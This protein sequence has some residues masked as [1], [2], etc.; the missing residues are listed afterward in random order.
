MIDGVSKKV[1]RVQNYG[2][3][4]AKT[5]ASFSFFP[6]P[7][8]TY[9][10]ATHVV[11]HAVTAASSSSSSPS[12]TAAVS[13]S[14]PRARCFGSIC[15]ARSPLLLHRRYPRRHRCLFFL[16]SPATATRRRDIFFSTR[17]TMFW[18]NL[19]SA[20]TVSP[21]STSDSCKAS[22]VAE[23]RAQHRFV[24]WRPMQR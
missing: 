14:V 19:Q 9:A 22:I 15:K 17:S 21:A 1:F 5:L 20:I 24:R 12:P 4:G 8:S 6:T 10:V 13:S 3:N 18:I 16:A 7:T 11:T 23:G 2:A